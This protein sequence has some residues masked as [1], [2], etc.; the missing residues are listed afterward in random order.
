MG[1]IDLVEYRNCH[2][3][4]VDDREIDL[5]LAKEPSEGHLDLILGSVNLSSLCK[6]TNQQLEMTHFVECNLRAFFET[7]IPDGYVVDSCIILALTADDSFV[8]EDEIRLCMDNG[9]ANL[10]KT[11]PDVNLTSQLWTLKDLI[12]ARYKGR[13]R[14]W[15]PEETKVP[16]P[17]GLDVWKKWLILPRKEC[18]DSL[19]RDLSMGM[20][21][22]V[23]GY[24]GVGKTTMVN[25]VVASVVE[26]L[27]VKKVHVDLAA[28]M[29]V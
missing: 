23:R 17:S 22:M 21:C 13:S 8:N 27:G 20:S 3:W 15:G 18:E 25:K 1:D 4:F 12:D 11:Y 2:L 5:V 6:T 19:E 24:A 14:A 10:Q 16:Y 7:K 9:I 26:K 28:V 29:D